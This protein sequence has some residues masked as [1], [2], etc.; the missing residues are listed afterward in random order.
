MLSN[1][2]GI[3]GI[4]VMNASA[5]VVNCVVY[6]N[7]GTALAEWANK[8]AARFYSC[9]FAAAAAYSGTASTV[10]NLTD[11]AFKDAANGN[12]RPKSNGALFNA[13]DNERYSSYATSLTDLDGGKRIQGRIIDI[14]CYEA[15]TGIGSV[16]Y[17]R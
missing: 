1:Q 6:N 14:G 7:G 13:G 4:Y 3:G 10:L 2:G 12:Y 15:S 16:Y 9:A 11:A 8:N 5:S 17:I